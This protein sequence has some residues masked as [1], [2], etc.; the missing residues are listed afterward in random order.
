MTWRHNRRRRV[1]RADAPLR[2]ARRSYFDVL[3]AT[4]SYV[5]ETE[6]DRKK[7]GYSCAHAP[8]LALCHVPRACLSRA[9]PPRA[10]PRRPAECNLGFFA[11]SDL[12]RAFEAPGK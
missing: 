11:A 8:A 6:A 3:K 12:C 7:L 5:P 4:S 10:L 9:R 2:N 1:A